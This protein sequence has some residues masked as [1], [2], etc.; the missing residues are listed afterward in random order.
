MPR[1]PRLTRR[2]ATA[3]PALLAAV[4]GAVLAAGALTSC[5]GPVTVGSAPDGASAACDDVMALLPEQLVGAPR[6]ETDGGAGTAAWGDPA[7][8]L[9]CGE[10]P[11]LT[12]S[13]PCVTVP[14]DPDG[15]DWVVL[16]FDDSGSIVRTFGRDPAVEVEV[17]AGYGP[18]PVSV[19][20]ELSEAVAAVGA[21]AVC[22]G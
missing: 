10:E 12:S 1:R 4:L 18:A 13:Q 15:V 6:R 7:I 14:G 16:A 20:P 5:G 2:H 9:R 3:R 17:P 19:L 22:S 11:V 21:A 8:L